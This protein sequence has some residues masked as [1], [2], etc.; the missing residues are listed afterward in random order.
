MKKKMTWLTMLAFLL[1]CVSFCQMDSRYDLVVKNGKIIAGDGNPWYK[2][3]IGI[4]DEKI[5]FIGDIREPNAKEIINAEGLYVCPGFIDIHSH[6]DRNIK[7]IPTADNYLLQGVTTTVGGNCGAHR[8]PLS[9]QFKDLKKQG[10]AINFGSL[11]GHSTIREE[12]MGLKMA[13]PTPH[14]LDSMK[15]L[16]HQEMK[17]GAIGLSTGLAY[18]PGRYSKTEELIELAGVVSEYGGLYASHIRNQGKEIIEAIEEAIR[19][20]EE[21]KLPV[22]ISHI[23]LCI[24]PNWGK[25]EMIDGPIRQARARGVNVAT[26]QYPYI[27]TSSGFSSSFP[28]WSLEGGREQLIERLKDPI[29]YKKVK[30][31]IIKGRLTSEKGIN[32]LQSITICNYKEG[33]EYEGKNLEEILKLQDKK[34]TISNGADLIIDIEKSGG[35][36]CVFFQMIEDDIDDI[37]AL[38]YN[39]IGSDGGIIEYEKGVPHCRGYGT[40]PRVIRKYVKEKNVLTLEEAIRKM[41]SLPAQALRLADRGLIKK[42]MFADLVIFDLNAINDTAT[43]QK[44]HQYPEG[45]AYVIVNGSISAEKGKPTGLMPGRILYGSGKK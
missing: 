42:H 8:F 32:K 4:K 7:K 31:H 1:M 33:P 13:D 11:I 23:K 19:I 36:S 43:F 5:V 17:S 27:A 39:M 14:E 22:Q 16:I 38:E 25:L 44:P 2:A 10:I 20:G 34:A 18:M 12:I 45:I 21:N 29:N 30:D 26:D 24:E 28:D 9:D 41:T 37:M 35:A 40:F 15:I 3:D 6:S